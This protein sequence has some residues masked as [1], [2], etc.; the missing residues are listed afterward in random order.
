VSSAGTARARRRATRLA[1]ALAVCAAL[2][3]CSREEPAPRAAAPVAPAPA[4]ASAPPAPALAPARAWALGTSA[5]LTERNRER[6]DLLAGGPRTEERAREWRENL[7]EW[8]GVRSREDLLQTLEWLAAEGH[9][10]EFERLGAELARLGDDEI[11]ALLASRGYDDE[12]TQKVEVVTRW[13]G[14]L[15]AKSLLGWDYARYVA[16]CRW[17]ALVGYLSEE[18]AWARI[19]PA[20]RRL[21]RAFGSW[22]ELGENY[23]IGRRFWSLRE[24]RASGRLYEEAYR[25]L[26]EDPQSPWTRYAWDTSLEE[27]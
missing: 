25:R 27:G 21:Q 11:K 26:L 3:A 16:L 1:A 17:G 22:R 5:L 9:R 2:A 19:M 20:A 6:H 14:R 24:T 18:E 4:V 8:W 13:Y 10:R 23:L 15:G 12:A 7:V